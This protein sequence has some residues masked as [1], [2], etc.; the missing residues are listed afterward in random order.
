MT[1]EGEKDDIAGIGQTTAAHDLCINIPASKKVDYLQ[2]DVGHYGI[3]NGSRFRK[4]IAP[5]MRE[6]WAMID[7]RQAKHLPAKVNAAKKS[8]GVKKPNGAA[9]MPKAPERVPL[10]A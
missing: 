3:F 1:V 5:R 9:L 4:E 6:F 2:L 7:G 8:N 10:P